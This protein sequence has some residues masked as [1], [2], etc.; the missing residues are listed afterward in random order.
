[1]AF[2]VSLIKQQ[3]VLFASIG[4]P[5]FGRLL[6]LVPF[7]YVLNLNLRCADLADSILQVLPLFSLVRLFSFGNQLNYC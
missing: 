4:L 7:K 1:M 6:S 3:R 5:Q 2:R